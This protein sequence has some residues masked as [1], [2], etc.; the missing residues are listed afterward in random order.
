M[1]VKAECEAARGKDCQMGGFTRILHSGQADDLMAEIPT[2]VVDPLP[3]RENK[4]CAAALRAPPYGKFGCPPI[5]Q[6]V[7]LLRIAN[8]G[9][10]LHVLQ[11]KTC[12][13]SY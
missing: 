12:V 5:K 10:C 4:G 1:Q 7:L 9:P 6:C 11:L 13:T 3:D 8:V 2:V